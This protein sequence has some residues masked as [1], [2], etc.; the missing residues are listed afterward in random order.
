MKPH[1]RM[2][3]SRRME[4]IDRGVTFSCFTLLHSNAPLCCS[5]EKN[6]EESAWRRAGEWRQENRAEWGQNEAVLSMTCFTLLHSTAPFYCS[7]EKNREE[8]SRME[9]SRSMENEGRM[10]QY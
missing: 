1:G 8:R 5:M 7:M 10:K 3:K 4:Q 6:R 2:V 9:K